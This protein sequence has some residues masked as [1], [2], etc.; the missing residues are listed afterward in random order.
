[1]KSL[2]LGMHSKSLEWAYNFRY[3]KFFE[4]V[5]DSFELQRGLNNWYDTIWQLIY[6]LLLLTLI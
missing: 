5:T 2:P 6:Y 4:N 3:V 1:M